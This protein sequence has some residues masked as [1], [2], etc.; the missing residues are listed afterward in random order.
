MESVLELLYL[1][2]VTVSESEVPAVLEVARQLNIL[3]LT[4]QTEHRGIRGIRH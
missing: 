1:G 2:H 3:Q 4:S